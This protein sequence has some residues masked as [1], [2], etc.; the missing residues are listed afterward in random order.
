MRTRSSVINPSVIN[1]SSTGKKSAICSALSTI[2]TTIGRSSETDHPAQRRGT[3]QPLFPG[4]FH[5]HL[6]ERPAVMFVGL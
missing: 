1:S 6:V 4:P 5:N 3:G 2:S